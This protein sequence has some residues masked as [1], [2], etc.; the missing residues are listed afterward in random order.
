MG[1]WILKDIKSDLWKF[2][3]DCMG[4][5]FLIY[6]KMCIFME[7]RYLFRIICLFNVRLVIMLYCEKVDLKI[8]NVIIK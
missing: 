4:L 2:F 1:V 7:C 3:K 8:D 5:V 6:F